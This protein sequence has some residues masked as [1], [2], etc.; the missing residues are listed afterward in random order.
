MNSMLVSLYCTVDPAP[1]IGGVVGNY[2][3]AGRYSVELAQA[4]ASCK[5]STRGCKLEVLVRAV[6]WVVL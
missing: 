5:L 4:Q 3:S 1:G 6:F 2:F